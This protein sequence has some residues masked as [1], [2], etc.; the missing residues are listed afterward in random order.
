MKHQCASLIRLCCPALISELLP[1][2][3]LE[4]HVLFHWG[5]SLAECNLY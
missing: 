4:P 2:G 3:T 1:L 5:T